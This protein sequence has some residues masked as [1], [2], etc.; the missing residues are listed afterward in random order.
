MSEQSDIAQYA[1]Q[2]GA[3]LSDLPEQVRNDLLEDLPAHLAE[4]AAELRAEGAGA[5]LADRLGPPSAYAAELRATLGH[6]GVPAAPPPWSAGPWAA[7]SSGGGGGPRARPRHRVRAPRRLPGPAAPGVVGGARLAGRDAGR[8]AVAG[9]RRAGPAAPAGGQHAARPVP[10]RR[11]R[12]RL[13]LVRSPHARAPAARRSARLAL[14]G[15]TAVLA[16]FGLVLVVEADDRAA[17]GYWET[18]GGYVVNPYDQVSDVF[19]LGA[20][21]QVIPGARIVDQTGNPV[22]I[23]WCAQSNHNAFDANWEWRIV[24][25]ACPDVTPPQLPWAPA[26]PAPLPWASPSPGG[27]IPSPSADPAT[28]SPSAAAPSAKPSLTPSAQVSPGS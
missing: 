26:S 28:A 24:Y 4:V 1:A 27:V 10:D 12:D 3:A 23:G 16:V 21:G 17:R 6:T 13:D 5:T 18:A 9:R 8:A 15:A 22:L 25:P 20:D 11:C 7:C 19:V 14:G 2:V